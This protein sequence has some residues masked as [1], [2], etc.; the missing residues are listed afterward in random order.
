MIRKLLTAFL[1]I[2]IIF[3]GYSNKEWFLHWIQVG[4][5]LSVLISI[6]FV[7][8]LVFFPIMPF[9]IAAGMIG[10]VFGIVKGSAICLLGA[11]AG[12]FIMFMMARYGFREW[13]QR[14]MQRYP[15]VQE[16]G[17]YVEKNAFLSILLVRII[18]VVP[19]P[20][21]NILSG[22]SQVR[23]TTF[24]LATLLGKIP[25]ILTFTFAG[26]LFANSMLAS[27]AIYG[28]YFL[29]I[30]M[31]TTFYIKKKEQSG[32]ELLPQSVEG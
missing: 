11:V 15:K 32:K 23:G 3:L 8:L 10:A 30:L 14:M 24:C 25:S 29:I 28:A 6:L 31:M 16:Y 19:P 4:G 27:V 26:S 17:A 13:V 21:V 1:F 9:P 22:V 2:A 18:P 7:S 5:S 12:A 20:A